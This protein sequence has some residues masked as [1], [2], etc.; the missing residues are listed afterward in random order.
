M[1]AVQVVAVDRPHLHT[2]EI[3][4]DQGFQ[5]Q[6]RTLVQNSPYPAQAQGS[7]ESLELFRKPIQ[8]I[9]MNETREWGL[10][11]L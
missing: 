3:E 4:V 9:V 11:N 6:S 1:D 8:E 2:S 5:G 7:R 10:L